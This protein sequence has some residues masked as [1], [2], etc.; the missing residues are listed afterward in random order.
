L[1]L[2]WC[3]IG[4]RPVR[5]AFIWLVFAFCILVLSSAESSPIFG[6]Y[7]GLGSMRTLVTTQ[8]VSRSRLH[9]L[10]PSL[11]SVLVAT[12]PL[13]GGIQKAISSLF[14][15][16]AKERLAN[17]A[18]LFTWDLGIVLCGYTQQL[19]IPLQAMDLGLL[20]KKTLFLV[21]LA[22][23]ARRSEV[24]A[25][26]CRVSSQQRP[27]GCEAVLSPV[28]GFV[29]KSRRGVSANRA[30]VIKALPVNP[31]SGEESALCPVK[32]SRRF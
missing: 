17:P 29:P 27:A 22:A 19:F 11:W 28:P 4:S 8:S 2:V 15:F 32:S 16:F 26:S 1:C 6:H 31:G 30:F 13:P 5:S 7:S 3:V 25:L 18:P 24:F 12:T 20:T 9:K 10:A 14:P 23:S 21:F